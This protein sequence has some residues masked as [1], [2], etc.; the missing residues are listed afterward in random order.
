MRESR[1]IYVLIGP[2]AIGKSTWIKNVTN[3]ENTIVISNDEMMEKAAESIGWTYDDMFVNPPEDAEIGEVDEKYGEVVPAPQWM[4]WR[5]NA[6]KKVSDANDLAQT[7]FKKSME[8]ARASDGNVVVDL[9]NMRVNDRVDI[10]KRVARP[11]DVKVAVIFNFKA[12]QNIIK[13]VATKRAE[14][15][16]RMGKSKTIPD[17]VIDK[18]ISGY[19]PPTPKEKYDKIIYSNT[20]PQLKKVA[21]LN[22][23]R[24]YIRKVINEF[25]ENKKHIQEIENDGEEK[26]IYKPIIPNKYVYHSSNPIFREKIS[27]MGLMPKPKSDSWLENTPIKGEVIFATNSDDKNEWFDSTYDD[28]I[29]KID[30]SKISNKWYEDP[31]FS[32]DKEEYVEFGGKKIKLPPRQG[33]NFYIITFEKIP[34]NAI[35][36]IYKGTGESKI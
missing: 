28:D 14:A 18:M 15:A 32:K 23:A 9:T 5:K 35:E 20:I 1:I 3:P 12:K 6:F 34:L 27:K 13:A 31:N 36:L 2:P 10:L 8:D 29:Y 17:V 24:T 30:T 21:G 19:E 11:N 7:N 33:E 25:F 22:E 26:F 16:K 4:H